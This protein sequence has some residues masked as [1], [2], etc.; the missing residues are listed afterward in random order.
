VSA[1]AAAAARATGARVEEFTVGPRY[2]EAGA[3]AGGHEWVVEFASP[4]AGGLDAFAAALDAE[5]QRLNHDYT[6]KRKGGLAMG[7]PSVREVA[8]GTFYEWMKARGKLGGQHKVPIC[9]NDRRYVDEL[10]R[11]R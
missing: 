2:P 4:P 10:A 5:L 6:I 9:A 8:R 1:A 3:T 11:K 7:P